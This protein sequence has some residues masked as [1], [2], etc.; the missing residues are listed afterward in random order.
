LLRKSCFIVLP[1]LALGLPASG[2]AVQMRSDAIGAV[3]GSV[4]GGGR[5]IGMTAGLPVTGRATATARVEIAGFWRPGPMPPAGADEAAGNA[6]LPL[7]TG[8]DGIDPNPSSDAVRIRFRLAGARGSAIPVRLDVYDLLG[9]RAASLLD[10]ILAPGV[11]F[12]QWDGRDAQGH[13]VASGHYYL[14]LTTGGLR[15]TRGI[16]I[17][18]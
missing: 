9:R 13:P 17:V 14:Q 7:T 2:H 18:R 3:A 4:T 15:E 6:G 11:H 16:V 1:A 5:I 8:F 10:D 12:N